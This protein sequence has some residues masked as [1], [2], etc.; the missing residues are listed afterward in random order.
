MEAAVQ[1][2][3]ILPGNSAFFKIEKLTEKEKDIVTIQLD[4]GIERKPRNVTV[5][6]YHRCAKEACEVCYCT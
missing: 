1:P 2:A 6:Q 4:A 3:P 5:Q